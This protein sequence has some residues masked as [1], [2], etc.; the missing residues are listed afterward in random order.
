[1]FLENGVQYLKNHSDFF[2]LIK[3]THYCVKHPQWN[4]KCYV[5]YSLDYLYIVPPYIKP[6]FQVNNYSR[7]HTGSFSMLAF[8]FQTAETLTGI[9]NVNFMNLRLCSLHFQIPYNNVS[10]CVLYSGEAQ[11]ILYMN[12]S[13]FHNITIITIL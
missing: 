11:N 8:L 4:L 13:F 7:W 9:L 1:M 3:I 6:L 2:F 10:H 12:E 5:F